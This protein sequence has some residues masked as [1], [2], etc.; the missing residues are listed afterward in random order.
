M[1][2][3]LPPRF[4]AGA[5]TRQTD[6]PV[7]AILPPAQDAGTVDGGGKEAGHDAGEDRR[8]IVEPPIYAIMAPR[9]DAGKT[10]APLIYPIL[11]ALPILPPTPNKA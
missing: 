6:V 9:R 8:R 4:D 11:P 10:D 1:W 5:D 7:Y 3:I 2:A